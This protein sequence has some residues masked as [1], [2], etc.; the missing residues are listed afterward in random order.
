MQK[1]LSLPKGASL[2]LNASTASTAGAPVFNIYS[3]TK[4]A[5][6]SFAHNWILDLKE[7]K[8]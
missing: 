8:I 4:A 3:P 7:R 2:I 5:V 6:R 1:A